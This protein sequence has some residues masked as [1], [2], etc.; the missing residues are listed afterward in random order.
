MTIGS[1][2][3]A[4][5]T[6]QAILGYLY[7]ISFVFVVPLSSLYGYVL[8]LYTAPFGDGGALSWIAFFGALL[9]SAH[10][11]R[12]KDWHKQAA[13]GP[14]IRSDWLR[15]MTVFRWM[16]RYFHLRFHIS[17]GLREFAR[18]K[19]DDQPES[20]G[21]F[22]VRLPTNVNYLMGYHPHGPLGWGCFLSVFTEAIEITKRLPGITTFGATLNINFSVPFTRELA[23]GL[24]ECLW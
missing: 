1:S 19:E 4:L 23:L 17:E 5:E 14:Q 3:T 6:A 10:W 9:Y 16:A 20:E 12:S 24:G 11:Y 22:S 21:D 18:R 7:Y 2:E 8:A 13:G 15:K